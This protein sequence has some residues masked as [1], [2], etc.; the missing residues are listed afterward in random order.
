[1]LS[2][3]RV[4]WENGCHGRCSLRSILSVGGGEDNSMELEEVVTGSL[5]GSGKLWRLQHLILGY[6]FIDSP[7]CLNLKLSTVINN[8]EKYRYGLLGDVCIGNGV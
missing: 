4:I 6:L 2:K 5:P 1:M 8:C 7:N 3:E